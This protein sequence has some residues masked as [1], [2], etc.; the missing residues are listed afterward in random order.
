MLSMF[1]L[2]MKLEILVLV[3]YFSGVR[4]MDKLASSYLSEF[5]YFNSILYSL[6]AGYSSGN[7][8]MVL[9]PVTLVVEINVPLT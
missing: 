8:I 9:L 7:V 4:L 1:S 6:S 5:L 3:L 2:L